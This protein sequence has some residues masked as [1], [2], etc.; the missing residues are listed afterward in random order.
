VDVPDL[1]PLALRLPR[2]EGALVVRLWQTHDGLVRH[3][4]PGVRP[5]PCRDSQGKAAGL[6][7]VGTAWYT[8]A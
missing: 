1:R 8:E 6:R 2:Q 7:Y 3:L 5:R 4:L